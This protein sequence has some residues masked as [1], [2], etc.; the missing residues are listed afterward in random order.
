MYPIFKA[1]ADKAG[2]K[3]VRGTSRYIKN[4]FS[5]VIYIH[6]RSYD[7]DLSYSRFLYKTYSM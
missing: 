4:F 6:F 2:G 7:C 3:N 5:Y 1:L